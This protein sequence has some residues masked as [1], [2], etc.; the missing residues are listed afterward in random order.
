[1]VHFPASHVY[2]RTKAT[3]PPRRTPFC[4]GPIKAGSARARDCFNTNAVLI[5]GHHSTTWFLLCSI[6]WKSLAIPALFG[7]RKLENDDI[8]V[9]VE[10]TIMGIF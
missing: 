1:M 3:D 2:L 8:N 9:V 10:P 7:W 6:L 4:D 5:S